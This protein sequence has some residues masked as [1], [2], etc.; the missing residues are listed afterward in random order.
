MESTSYEMSSN[1][2]DCG[3]LESLRDQQ[4]EK[5]NY[6]WKELNEI[7]YRRRAILKRV[8]LPLWKILLSWDGTCLKVLSRDWLLW[9]PLA[10]YTVI[11]LQARLGFLPVFIVDLGDAD[12]DIL[13]GFLSFFLVLFVN[14]SNTRFTEMYKVGLCGVA[15]VCSFL[16]RVIS[17]TFEIA[18]PIHCTGIKEVRRYNW[19][20]FSNDCYETP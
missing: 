5:Q 10:I 1:N 11:R 6:T 17:L 8:E 19:R 7:E 20:H 3:W 15:V 2:D 13:G 14:Q 12:I 4:E 18:F 16:M 9:L